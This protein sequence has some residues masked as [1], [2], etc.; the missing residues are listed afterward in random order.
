MNFI[1]FAGLC[2][3]AISV[4]GC[5]RR[6][7]DFTIISTKNMDLSQTS[8]FTRGSERVTGEDKASIIVI[9]P[10][11]EPDLKEAIDRAIESTPGAVGLVDGVVR[12]KWFY[13]PYIYGETTYEVEGTPLIDSSKR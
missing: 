6:I 12:Y 10:T 8:G 13:I 5:T 11:G 7:T 1:R 9:I 4:V 2:I 3:I